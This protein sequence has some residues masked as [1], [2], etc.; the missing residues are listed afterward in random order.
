MLIGEQ[1]LNPPAAQGNPTM[2][3][4]PQAMGNQQDIQGSKTGQVLGG[5][6][7][8]PQ[9]PAEA[10]MPEMPTPPAPFENA[11]TDPTQM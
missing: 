5:E 1:P 3:Q 4:G 10:G 6:N 11:P 2:P 8:I 9:M 7:M